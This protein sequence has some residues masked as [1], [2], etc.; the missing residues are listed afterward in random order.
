[1]NTLINAVRRY[2]ARRAERRRL[3]DWAWQKESVVLAQL[4]ADVRMAI[5]AVHLANTIGSV[6]P[7]V[8]ELLA[9]LVDQGYADLTFGGA[10]TYGGARAQST[11]YYLTPEGLNERYRRCGR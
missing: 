9:G 3:A 10:R 5:S 8:A 2:L 4:T 6:V 11:R 1:V 7:D